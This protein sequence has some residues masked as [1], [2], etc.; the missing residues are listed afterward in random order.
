[1]I[2]IHNA[3]NITIIYHF[4][5]GLHVTLFTSKSQSKVTLSHYHIILF[6]DQ[7]LHAPGLFLRVVHYLGEDL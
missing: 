6:F 1:M 3:R 7:Y 4:W 2:V 5:E